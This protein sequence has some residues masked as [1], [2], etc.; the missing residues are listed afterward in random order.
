LRPLLVALVLSCSSGCALRGLAVQSG[1]DDRL[2]TVEVDGQTFRIQ[3]WN[4]DAASAAQLSRSLVRSVP[5]VAKWGRLSREVTIT[6]YPSH[7]ALEAAVH[8][9][10]LDWLRAFARYQ[11]I[12][13]QS[14][15]TW[16]WF[17]A[18]D[19]E[20]D[21]LLTHELTH[22]AMYQTAASEWTWPHKGIPLW[23]QEGLASVTA[24]EG[25]H[26]STPEELRRFYLGSMPAPGAG[27]GYPRAVARAARG[28]YLSSDGD[29]V[30]DPEPLYQEGADIV[31]GAAYRAVEFLRSRYGEER[32]RAI[33]ARMHEGR[34]FEQAFAES[35]G[36][37]EAAFAS[38]FRRYVLWQGWR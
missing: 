34:A 22:C 5:R 9:E 26:R 19:G 2:E 24:G 28:G 3:Y 33:M 16:G 12:D 25:R 21:E 20:V 11:T 1:A 14:P 15:R 4:E 32:V 29:P 35:I 6:I 7:A 8:R 17:A 31:Y 38:E 30:T 10:G 27:D 13:L 23:F 36:I 18:S 37:S